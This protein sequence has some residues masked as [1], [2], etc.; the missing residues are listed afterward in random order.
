[1]LPV[2]PLN[3]SSFE[4]IRKKGYLYVDK[5]P[6]IY[7]LLTEGECYFLSRPRRFGK[8]LTV[9][10]LKELFSGNKEL[11]KSYGFTINGTLNLIQ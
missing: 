10:T 1:M 5:T 3:T 2:L 6:W 9:S 7:K 4:K 11:F 8:S